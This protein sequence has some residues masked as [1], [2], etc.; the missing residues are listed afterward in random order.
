MDRLINHAVSYPLALVI[1]GAGFGKT[2][3]V[4]EWL[5]KADAPHAWISLTDGDSEVFWDKL[6][7]AVDALNSGAAD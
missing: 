4:R 1:A 6:C 2:T 5:K 3:A 7:D